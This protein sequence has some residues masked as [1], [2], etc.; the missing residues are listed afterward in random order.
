MILWN[1]KLIKAVLGLDKRVK[2]LEN[3]E[4]LIGDDDV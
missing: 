2:V 4:M 3:F 1:E